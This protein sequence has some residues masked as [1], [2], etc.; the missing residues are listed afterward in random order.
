MIGWITK[1]RLLRI[2]LRTIWWL[3]K[4]TVRS[5]LS[6]GQ[7]LGFRLWLNDTLICSTCANE[8]P[9]LGLFQ[10]SACTFSFYAGYFTDCPN[11][12]AVPMYLDCPT[13]GASNRNPTL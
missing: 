6:I 12:G 7:A 1:N 5:G 8:L 2:A 9:L 10:C 3:L 4:V 11:C 13:C